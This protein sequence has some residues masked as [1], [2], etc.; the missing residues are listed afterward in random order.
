MRLSWPCSCRHYTS[1]TSRRA[2]LSLLRKILFYVFVAAYAIIGPLMV[3][4]ALGYI[5]R[6]GE[7]KGMVPTGLISL[8]TEPSGATVYVGNKRYSKK[9]PAVV[10]NLLPGSYPVSIQMKGHRGWSSK[11]PVEV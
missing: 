1:I 11:V 10:R 9:T 4:Y 5:F 7:E 2:I 3:L 8:A 6:P